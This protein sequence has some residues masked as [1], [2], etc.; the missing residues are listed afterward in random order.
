[1]RCRGGFSIKDTDLFFSFDL[2]TRSS[3]LNKQYYSG[4][5]TLLYRIIT[6]IFDK[7]MNYIEI[8]D[9]LNDNGYTTSR[10]KKFRNAQIP[11]PEWVLT[12]R[13]VK[14][15]EMH[16]SP[17]QKDWSSFQRRFYWWKRWCLGTSMFLHPVDCLV[18]A[19]THF[20]AKSK[21]IDGDFAKHLDNCVS[22]HILEKTNSQ[23]WLSKKY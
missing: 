4:Y 20:S 8:A 11:S 18:T 1:M 12:W 7:G 13:G 16:R 2:V 9:W 17:L 10:G 15:P 6:E 19:H 5:Q 3:S 14:P 23:I 22:Q 21:R